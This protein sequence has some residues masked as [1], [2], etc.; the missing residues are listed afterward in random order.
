MNKL[1]IRRSILSISS[2]GTHLVFG[3]NKLAAKLTRECNQY[4][5][6]LKKRYPDRFGYFASL[7]LPAVETS[8]KE[9]ELASN[10]GC[11]GFVVLTN[12]HGTYVGDAT[13]DP[14]FDELNRRE[15]VVFFHPTTPLCP[16]SPDALAA[17][18]HL[19]KATPFAGRYP[20]PMLEFLFDTTRAIVN[21]FLS[22]T[23]RRCPNI[24]FIFS[25]LGGTM[26]PVLSRF[27]EYANFVPVPWTKT[28]ELEVR[29]AFKRQIWFDLAGFPFPGQIQGLLA[30]GGR[31]DKLL[32]GR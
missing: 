17:G 14:I 13:L 6:G 9:I 24:Q 28:N 1:N 26:P 20:N 3:D 27:S 5:A 29:D 15:A 22:G 30:A 8:L 21:L 23:V 31:K 2:P 18:Q 10:E 32:C 19:V 16:C 4:A 25:H 12:G 11:D 7:P